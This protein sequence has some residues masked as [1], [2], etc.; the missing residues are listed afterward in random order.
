MIKLRLESIYII[1]FGSILFFFG[2]A[3]FNA[4]ASIAASSLIEFQVVC[5]I[6]L[7]AIRKRILFQ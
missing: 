3:L 5:F 1:F 7:N 2:R 4:E 6:I